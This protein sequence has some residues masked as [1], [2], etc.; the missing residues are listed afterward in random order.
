MHN[1]IPICN[2]GFTLIEVMVVTAIMAMLVAILLP[3]LQRAREQA[4]NTQ[5]LSTLRQMGLAAH[6]YVGTYGRFPPYLYGSPDGTISYGWDLR[7]QSRWE[8]GERKTL[9]KPGLL[10]QGMGVD[11]I[12]QCPSYVGSDNWASYP[13]TGYNYNSSYVGYCEYNAEITGW[14]PVPTGRLVATANPVRPEDIRYPASC[15]MFGDGEYTAGANKFMRAPFKGR[16]A[17]FSGRSAGTQG[18]RHLGKTN[19]AFCDG[20]AVS[21]AERYT[22]TYAF[23]QG[24]IQPHNQVQTGF[25]SRDNR[26]YDLE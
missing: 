1:P 16:D 11:Q 19:V 20:H 22:E 10:W 21:W 17:S 23:D 18:Y 2:K 25:L 24:N 26:I 8:S 3:A 14:P 7:V 15:A 4:R 5:C 13:Y 12:N 6:G 9:I